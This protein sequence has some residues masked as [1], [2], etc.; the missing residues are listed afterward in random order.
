QMAGK[1]FGTRLGAR[2][3]PGLAAISNAVVNERDTRALAD[4][5]IDFYRR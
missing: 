3:I 1:R 4:R 5:A 2:M